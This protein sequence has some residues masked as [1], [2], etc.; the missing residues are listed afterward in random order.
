M[1]ASV[2][3]L[4][5]AGVPLRRQAVLCRSN[6]RLNDFAAA[7]EERGIAVLHLGSLF[8][9][10]E[11]RDLLA[12]LSLAV[13]R[14]GDAL[15]RVASM[16]GYDV[17]LQD[18]RAATRHLRSNGGWALTALE[19]LAEADGVSDEGAAG[20]RRLAD[21]L[22]GLNPTGSAWGFLSSYLL[23]RTDFVRK[24]ARATTVT[25]RMRA[26]AVWQFLNFVRERS[27]TGA[28]LPIR[29]TL[30]RVRQ[31]VLLAEER[32]LRQVPAAALHLDA[33]RLMTVHG[34]KGLEFD[35]V[36]VPGLTSAS[37][38]TSNRGQ[39][40]PPPAG[41]IDGTGG[42]SVKEEFKRSH[43]HEEQC[44]F[45]VALSRAR[46]HVRLH[47]ARKQANGRNRSPSEFLGWLPSG[48]FRETGPSAALSS[49]PGTASPSCDQGNASVA[50]GASTDSGL[51]AYEKCPRRFFYKH[52]PRAW[53]FMEGYGVFA[54]SL[55][56][57]SIHRLDRRG[58][59]TAGTDARGGRGCVRGDLEEARTNRACVLRRL[60]IGW[61]RAWL[62]P[63]FEQ[64][65]DGVPSSLDLSRSTCRTVA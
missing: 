29:R 57:P 47:L 17:N 33:V 30:D 64:A 42:L 58:A 7:L 51:R 61:R 38:P 63:S 22:S 1:A 21:D 48:L 14:F 15:V 25:E 62:P 24:L 45:F 46:S 19:S 36:H 26:V 9:R 37:F 13:D 40:C 34:S 2:R 39:R 49:R 53:W 55:L 41:M 6:N 54:H 28:G 12:L 59:A 31:L 10:E 23:D 44:L 56:P 32:D 4:K 35:A 43:V 18:V 50:N 8:E 20:F 52:H 3:E 65:R 60:P 27:P 11:V 5:D 16:P